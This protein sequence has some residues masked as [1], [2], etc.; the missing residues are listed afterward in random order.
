MTVARAVPWPIDPVEADEPGFCP[1]GPTGKLAYWDGHAWS[2][3]RADDAA[4]TEIPHQRTFLPF[5]RH[6][7]FWLAASGVLLVYLVNYVSDTNGLKPLAWVSVLGYA[8]AM[9]AAVL[10]FTRH[11]GV[12]LRRMPRPVL[13]WGLLSGLVAAGLAYGVEISVGPAVDS[14]PWVDGFSA[15]V[16][17]EIAKLA[18]PVALLIWGGNRFS[19]PRTGLVLAA[20]SGSVFAF[21]EG[22]E[23][24]LRTSSLEAT[25]V[26]DRVVV[27]LL[28]PFLTVLVAAVIWLAAWRKG[29]S[30]TIAGL[31]ALGIAAGIHGFND[32]LT[33]AI[34]NGD[35]TGGQVSTDLSAIE[36]ALF[37]GV[38]WLGIMVLLFLIARVAVRELVPPGL[39]ATSS[40]GWRPRIH[41]W[42][43][44]R[45]S[46]AATPKE[47]DTGQVPD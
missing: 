22:V 25:S 3:V 31:A 17:E 30:F 20:V 37:G 23:Y 12:R 11:V 7:W 42:G 29:R 14:K 9:S 35:S 10:I 26:S 32:G 41:Q 33:F 43:V 46:S 38:V 21:L 47:R 1:Y 27:E 28:H 44:P 6:L 16:I 36:P 34:A 4:V 40:K 24:Q 45:S 39:V 15:G 5:L 18:V 19:S 2:G 8:L 13:L